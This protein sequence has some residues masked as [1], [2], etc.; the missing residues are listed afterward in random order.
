MP[1]KTRIRRDSLTFRYYHISI[2]VAPLICIVLAKAVG[3]SKVR[4]T[5]KVR[6]TALWSYQRL[7]MNF[8]CGF[9]TS[10][11]KIYYFFVEE[12]KRKTPKN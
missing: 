7:N 11:Q 5:P 6:Q 2:N 4:Q 10:D 9:F 1:K 12:M 8:L 3:L